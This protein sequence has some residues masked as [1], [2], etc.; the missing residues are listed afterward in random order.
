VNQI[1]IGATILDRELTITAM[2]VIISF[3]FSQSSRG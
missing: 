1:I 3:H 2:K